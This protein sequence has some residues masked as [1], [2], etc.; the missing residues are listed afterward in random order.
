MAPSIL[1]PMPAPVEEKL[2]QLLDVGEEPRVSACTDMDAEGHF[3]GAWLVATERRLLI[4]APDTEA[5]TE[6][7]ARPSKTRRRLTIGRSPAHDGARQP[8]PK[9]RTPRRIEEPSL[10]EAELEATD[11]ASLTV[12]QVP[13]ENVTEIKTHEYVG[14]GVLEVTVSDPDGGDEPVGT[15]E[16]LRYSRSLSDKFS[17]VAENLE[18]LISDQRPTDEAATVEAGAAG[19]VSPVVTDSSA[20]TSTP[21]LA[22]NIDK[23]DP[24]LRCTECHRVLPKGT[25]LL[26]ALCRPAR[27]DVAAVHLSEAVPPAGRA[28][29]GPGARDDRCAAGSA[30][31]D[32][33]PTGPCAHPASEPAHAVVDRGG[34][35]G[36]ARRP[37][38]H[39]GLAQ[40]AERLARSVDHLRSAHPDLPASPE[41][42]PRILR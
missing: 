20:T 29:P 3:R 23:P 35:G 27:G 1:E 9:R 41:A 6:R 33:L 40:L 32:G 38:R 19:E 7:P 4:V 16:V 12:L 36:A 37:Y 39:G 14:S 24:K 31:A 26:P 30:A 18:S 28:F 8:F 21:V 5:E 25:D 22:P 2:E 15:V 11:P 42:L 10:P 17:Q 34:A 13:F